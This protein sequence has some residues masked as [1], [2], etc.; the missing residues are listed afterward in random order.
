[1]T[2]KE[3]IEEEQPNYIYLKNNSP[4]LVKYP[5]NYKTATE[6]NGVTFTPNSDGSIRVV[7]TSNAS[8]SILYTQNIKTTTNKQ[9]TLSGYTSGTGASIVLAPA[10]MSQNVVMD[11]VHQTK[12]FT[13][14]Y[15]D[16]AMNIQI[17]ANTTVDATFYPQVEEGIVAT[18]YSLN[19]GDYPID[20]VVY[21]G[22]NL[23]KPSLKSASTITGI[24]FTPNS[25]GTI[26]ASG[27]ATAN[28]TCL[29]GTFY[30]SKKTCT[31]S[32]CPSGGSTSTYTLY[33][34]DATTNKTYYDYGAGQGVQIP[35]TNPVNLYIRVFSGATISGK[36]F[37]PQIE[38]GSTATT[39]EAYTEEVLWEVL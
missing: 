18:Q 25:D 15:T 24:T 10:N 28:A 30:A 9:Y 33:A 14:T 37:K 12:T 13:A 21:T 7:G 2:L 11:T 27:T 39:F 23:F 20:K 4:N 3:C 36:I 19:V 38:V 6:K 5:Y 26:T 22:K 34:Y 1:M 31:L 32:G 8:G 16:Y 17:A 29:I 35:G